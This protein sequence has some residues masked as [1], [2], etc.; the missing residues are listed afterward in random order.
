MYHVAFTITLVAATVL[1]SIGAF[2]DERITNKLILWPARMRSVGEYYRLL[3]SGFIHADFMHL[4]FNMFT[5]YFMGSVVERQFVR[6]GITPWLYVLLYT[7]GIVVASLPSFFRHKSNPYW[8]SLG[9]S[10]GVAAVLFSSVYFSPWE[11][12]LIYFIKMP[13]IVFAVLYL[14]YSAFM[15]RRGGGGIN[16]DAHFWGAVFG[17]LFTLAIDPSHG[18]DFFRD[19]LSPDF[20]FT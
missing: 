17:F 11:P 18:T 12:L 13:S 1:I 5:L 6:M 3:T 15:S 20:S 9:A 10:G 14:A 19:I 8:R 7:L 4:F 16:H 2:S